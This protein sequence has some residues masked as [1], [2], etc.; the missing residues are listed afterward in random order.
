MRTEQLPLRQ[1]GSRVAR[2]VH[3]VRLVEIRGEVV[4]VRKREVVTHL[5]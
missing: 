1:E 5:V 2:G 4:D 3:D